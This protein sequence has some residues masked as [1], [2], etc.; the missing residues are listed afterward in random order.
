M[1]TIF[2]L[3]LCIVLSVSMM[4]AETLSFRLSN[5]RIIYNTGVNYF[6]FDILMKA[7]GN[8][9]YLYSSQVICNVNIASF[10]TSSNPSFVMGFETGQ[11]TSFPNPPADKYFATTSWASN[12]LNI[13]VYA[14]PAFNGKTPISG[15]YSEVT[16]SWQVFGTV[17]AEIA[18]SNG[19]AG[20]NFQTTALNGYQK[21]AT[22][23]SPYYSGYYNSPN[24][25]EGYDF[26]DLYLA[27]IFSGPSVWTQAGGVVDWS[28]SVNT[29]VW[30]STASIAVTDANAVVNNLR[31]HPAAKLVVN[32]NATLT[33]SGT[34][35]N[36]AGNNGLIIKS[37]VTGT[38]S[39]LHNT[40]N[41][42]A[43]IRRYITGSPDLNVFKY[44]F[45]SVPLL[46]SENPT[47]N[48]FLDSYL[49]NFIEGTNSWYGFGAPTNTPLYSDHGYM[50]YSPGNSFTYNFAGRMN[51][52]A[53]SVPVTYTGASSN[54]GWNLVPNPYPSAIDWLAP[55]GWSKS[56]IDNAV[57][58]WPSTAGQSSTTLNYTSFV[59]GVS[60]LLGSQYIA[61]GQSFFVHAT[62]ASTLGMDNSVRLHNPVIFLKN[63]EIVPDLLRISCAAGNANDEM[64]IRFT[65]EASSD[66]DSDFDAY[67]LQGGADA[68]QLNSIATDNSR[69]SINSLPFNTNET[70]VP[71]SFSFNAS[72]NVTFTASGMT[73]F[74]GTNPIYLEDRALGIMINLRESPVYT[75]S[76]ETGS[77]AN[78][79][80]LH[81]ASVTG[82]PEQ[83]NPTA[84]NAFITDRKLYVEV[85]S[86]QRQKAEVAIY[87]ALGQ[88][89]YMK[90]IIMNG[91]TELPF[92][93]APGVFIV[94][95][96]SSNQVYVTKI[97]K[98]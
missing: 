45:V 23:L 6:V 67:K 31:I 1:K 29:S 81:F 16:T 22:G 2:S 42:P 40:D 19:N 97:V 49:F 94:R 32:P 70:V 37:D 10:N 33:V 98:N 60:L 46:Q 80:N 38:G 58:V 48:L 14:N 90:Q 7:S 74:T 69:L 88:Q 82:I 28:A 66:F 65:G 59:N 51:N 71:V 57:Y 39:L 92:S 61:Q 62:T 79:F 12:N 35:T 21:Y 68:P 72:S 75:F 87:N 8:G 24:L 47:S 25:Y 52:G 86:M 18:N 15:A 53:F 96:T 89:L 3:F 41:V 64:V 26:T 5:P 91:L 84:G 93:Y 44:H 55:G 4:A 63:N 83:P 36:S 56:G 78:R 54:P 27:R 77:D 43:T 85:P 95:V 34:L 9:T 50:I 30:D 76:Y 13:A 11:F 17:Y 73:T 20:I